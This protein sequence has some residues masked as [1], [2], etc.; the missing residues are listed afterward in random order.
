MVAAQVRH[1]SVQLV[2]PQQDWPKWPHAWQVPPKQVRVVPAHAEPAQQGWPAPPQAVH[3]DAPHTWLALHWAPS[4]THAPPAVQQPPLQAVRFA[5][6]QAPPHT[7]VFVLQLL[8]AGQS[9]ATAQLQNVPA[10]QTLPALLT[11]QSRQT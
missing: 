4:A 5:A 11:P 2:P 9:V 8:F 6:P 3:P 10:E 1:L 7:W